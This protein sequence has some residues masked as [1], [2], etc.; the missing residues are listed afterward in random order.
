M[1]ELDQ[2]SLAYG[3]VWKEEALYVVPDE[4]TDEEAA[5]LMCG[6]AT[7]FNALHM[8]N[9]KPTDRVGIIGVG[10][11]GHLAIQVS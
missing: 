2:G 4:L 3:A 1:T 5:P 9:A 11:L 6:G 10:G 8:H 7:V